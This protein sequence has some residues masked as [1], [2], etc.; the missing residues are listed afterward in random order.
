MVVFISSLDLDLTVYEKINMPQI[1][2]TFGIKYVISVCRLLRAY[3]IQHC[4][5]SACFHL[6]RLSV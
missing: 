6:V 5:I 1:G 3:L 4:K 2:T